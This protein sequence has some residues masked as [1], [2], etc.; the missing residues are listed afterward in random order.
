MLCFFPT[1]SLDGADKQ[2]PMKSS[3]KLSS[4]PVADIF[5]AWATSMLKDPGAIPDDVLF[6]LF[7]TLE[8]VS[9]AGSSKLK[10]D[11]R[12]SQAAEVQQ[13]MPAQNTARRGA[14]SLMWLVIE[15]IQLNLLN[16]RKLGEPLYIEQVSCQLSRLA[17]AR[18]KRGAEYHEYT[19]TL[20]LGQLCATATPHTTIFLQNLIMELP[21]HH[22][23]LAHMVG[24]ALERHCPRSLARAIKDLLPK[25][26]GLEKPVLD[27]TLR[28]IYFL[29]FSS[30]VQSEPTDISLTEELQRT[31]RVIWP[32]LDQEQRLA[33]LRILYVGNVE[34]APR[35]EPWRLS[36]VELLTLFWEIR[37][38]DAANPTMAWPLMPGLDLTIRRTPL[39]VVV[40]VDRIFMQDDGQPNNRVSAAAKRDQIVSKPM[41]LL[42]QY[43]GDK[44]ESTSAQPPAI[45]REGTLS[46][47]KPDA[48]ITGDMMAMGLATGK[49]AW[50]RLI[51]SSWHG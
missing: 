45:Q 26:S 19:H 23:P 3:G 18:I 10:S 17:L 35:G 36:T 32:T 2:R 46:R 34:K 41:S 47:R 13:L 50:C 20:S 42:S 1:L 38:A 21:I 49:N 4:E 25:L 37:S 24:V 22:L 28:N 11:P 48:V 9:D 27:T 30:K 39:A 15:K 5:V 6:E 14:T 29:R 7:T 8:Q 43:I 16:G 51:E 44:L 12:A 33:M 31:C 40:L